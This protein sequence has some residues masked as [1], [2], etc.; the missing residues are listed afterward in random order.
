M[1]KL[2][3]TQANV[4]KKISEIKSK[5]ETER[6]TISDSVKSTVR[7]WLLQ[8]FE[9][10]SEYER[11]LGMWPQSMRE[12]SGFMMGT[13]LLYDEWTLKVQI[14]DTP[15]PAQGKTKHEASVS[16]EWNLYGE[17]SL[18]ISL[19]MSS[20]MKGAGQWA[21]TLTYF[22]VFIALCIIASVDNLYAQNTLLW[23]VDHPDYLPTSYLLGTFHVMGNSFIDSIPE[24]ERSLNRSDLAVFETLEGVETTR[25][26]LNARE[27]DFSYRESFSKKELAQLD[28]ISS[29]WKV[30]ISKLRPVELGMKIGSE[31]IIKMCG[32]VKPTDKWDHFET[33]IS[34]L[35]KKNDMDLVGLE[36]L[37]FQIEDV[38]RYYKDSTWVD[39]T[40]SISEMMK[41]MRKVRAKSDACG[42]AQMYMDLDL[43]YRFDE[44]CRDGSTVKPRNDHWML[45]LPAMLA[46]NKTFVVVGLFHL[47]G[48]CGLI[49]QLRDLGYVVEPVELNY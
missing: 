47:Y 43:D 27:E 4:D 41:E 48:Q 36:S 31:Y 38:V 22:G 42:F 30:P 10:N 16:G 49:V 24:I 9:F 8:N 20:I 15:V 3:F 2:P 13:V 7:A 23:K 12:E 44:P 37:K 14:T 32:T 18:Q 35:A 45:Q 33:Y 26:L 25:D 46:E 6:R 1:E 29:D 17:R 34:H 21:R 5:S 28:E 11:R 19:V 39:V 40:E